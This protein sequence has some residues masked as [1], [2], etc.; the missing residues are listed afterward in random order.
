MIAAISA[1]VYL[2]LF[3]RED[4]KD[5]MILTWV[6]LIYFAAITILSFIVPF[7]WIQMNSSILSNFVLI[8]IAF[9]SMMAKTP[10]TIQYAKRS[11]EPLK[12]KHPLFI[13]INY[14]LTTMW[15]LL[16]LLTLVIDYTYAYHP[17]MHKSG[18]IL[19]TNIIWVIGA[20]ASKWFP[21]YWRSVNS[22]DNIAT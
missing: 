4:L 15:G 6:A 10:F 14:I 12:W 20:I 1:L 17:W 13:Q 3:E 8:C 16:F 11:V 21:A 22:Y 5:K 19:L 7:G 9:G 18:Y 2:L